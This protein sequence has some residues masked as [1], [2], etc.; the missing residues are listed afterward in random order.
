[1]CSCKLLILY[2]LKRFSS[3]F[4]SITWQS[5]ANFKA[6]DAELVRAMYFQQSGSVFTGTEK[7]VDHSIILPS[8]STEKKKCHCIIAFRP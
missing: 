1:M 7:R 4:A 6:G 8:I 5:K 3:K 2:I